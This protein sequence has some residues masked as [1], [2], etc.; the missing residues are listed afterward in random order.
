MQIEGLQALKPRFSSIHSVGD[1]S[2]STLLSS[3]MEYLDCGGVDLS[4]TNYG[5]NGARVAS[6]DG[7][8]DIGLDG[9]SSENS[10]HPG[11][12]SPADPSV[13]SKSGFDF[14]IQLEEPEDDDGIDIGMG[15]WVVKICK[16][17]VREPVSNKDPVVYF[18]TI[19]LS[20]LL[21]FVSGQKQSLQ[22]VFTASY[23]I[24]F[25]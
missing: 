24:D 3:S 17:A 15:G 20:E 8:S 14:E 13:T 21:I 2:D 23:F 6:D 18:F 12:F 22:Q 16:A 10:L 4:P 5:Q 7:V 19:T 1:V 9:N 11:S 25:S